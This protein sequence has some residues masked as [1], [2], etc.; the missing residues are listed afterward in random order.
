MQDTR[1]IYQDEVDM[2]EIELLG[3]ER[4]Q[5]M[6]AERAAAERSG[7]A[8]L[9]RMQESL[10]A[11]EQKLDIAKKRLYFPAVQGYGCAPFRSHFHCVPPTIHVLLF[12][13][14]C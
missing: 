1:R 13:L 4:Q 9:G 10:L 11:T 12:S 5:R 3:R 14:H 6:A 2:V 8:E 7:S